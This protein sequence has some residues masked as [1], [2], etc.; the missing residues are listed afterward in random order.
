MT[1]PE[2]QNLRRLW[3]AIG[4]GTLVQA[5]SFGS[6]LLGVVASQS[7]EV[8]AGGPA[9]AVGFA[10]VPIVFVIVALGSGRVGAAGSV[11]KGMG[12]W[13]LIALPVGLINPVTGL[14]AGFTAAGAVTVH[15]EERIPFRPRLAAVV[16]AAGYVT[17]LLFL[18]PQA[19]IFAGAVTPLLAIRGADLWSEREEQKRQQAQGSTGNPG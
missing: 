9:F 13:L 18:L 4:V 19:G 5:I 10:L 1:T 3:L 16:M 7:D 8:E 11:L 12:L 14:C 2:P 17:L 15:R 6:L